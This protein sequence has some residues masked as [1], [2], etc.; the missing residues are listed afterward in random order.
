MASTN[1]TGLSQGESLQINWK[2]DKNVG[3]LSQP[4]ENA[5][6]LNFSQ[7]WTFG[8]GAAQ[9]N[10]LYFAVLSIA[11]GGNQSL[12]LTSLMEILGQAGTTFGSLVEVYIRLLAASDTMP[13]GSVG[14][15]CSGITIG[16]D[17]TAN[18]PNGLFLTGRDVAGDAASTPGIVLGNGEFIHWATA[19]A[20]GIVVDG[21]HKKLLFT[22][23][24]G[25]VTAKVCVVLRGRA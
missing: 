21:T 19:L 3:G 5:N 15:A 23:N 20:A 6:T 13:D 25:S 16:N 10:E 11:G 17:V 1:L 12:D 14:S 18:N 7:N 9:A 24:D 4:S 2:A 22:N 8:T